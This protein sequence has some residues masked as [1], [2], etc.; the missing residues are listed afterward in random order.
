MLIPAGYRT[1]VKPDE[2]DEMM[3]ILYK[4]QTTMAR[5]KGAVQTGIL[6]A[7][8]C[9]AEKGAE[10]I[11]LGARVL[12]SKFAGAEYEDKDMGRVLVINDEDIQCEVK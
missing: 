1:V 3:G 8:G 12:F 7:K 2:V 9:N 11:P 5:E 4:P 10:N 6:L